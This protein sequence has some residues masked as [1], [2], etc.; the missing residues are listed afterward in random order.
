MARR[1]LDGVLREHADELLSLPGV[2]G[3]AQGEQDGQP[4][5]KLFVTS[6]VAEFMAQLPETLDG[7]PVVV[8]ETGRFTP[9]GL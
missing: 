5:I 2:V 7:Y 3:V 4:C 6:S 1:A 9:R 8:E